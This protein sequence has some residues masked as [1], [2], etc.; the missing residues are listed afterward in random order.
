MNSKVCVSTVVDEK[1]QYYIPLFVL[2]LTRAYPTYHIKIFTHGKIAPEVKKA[3]KTAGG[4][5]ELIPGV[6]DGWKKHKYS[7]I[8]WRFLVP[9]SYYKGHQYVYV[10]DID[11][12][13]TKERLPLYTFHKREMNNTKLCYSNSLRNKKHWNGKKSLSGLHFV[14]M[15]WFTKTEKARVYF[16]DKVKK[17]T[18]GRKREYDGYMLWRMVVKSKLKMCKKKSLVRRHHGIHIGSF[19]LYQKDSKIHKRINKQKCKQWMAL[20]KTPEFKKIY[21]LIK[22]DKTVK[23]QLKQ[24]KAHCK[25]VVK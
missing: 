10:T 20:R 17:G 7:P 2:S 23:S 5:C 9:P 12:M 4:S 21:S 14:N 15:K 25:E 3:L 8:S 13:I 24:L 11:M 18:A 16:A 1:Y 22:V 19:R 6:F